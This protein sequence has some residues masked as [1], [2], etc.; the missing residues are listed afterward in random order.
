MDATEC[1]YLIGKGDDSKRRSERIE[2]HRLNNALPTESDVCEDRPH[3]LATAYPGSRYR[4]FP[5]G[6]RFPC[7]ILIALPRRVCVAWFLIASSRY[8][9]AYS[10]RVV[11]QLLPRQKCSLAKVMI[12]LHANIYICTNFN[13]RQS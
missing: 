7:L 1:A 11:I 13:S 4:K 5:R 9:R 12:T 2:E 6:S 10:F 8:S 3:F